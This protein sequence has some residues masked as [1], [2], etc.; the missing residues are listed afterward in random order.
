MTTVVIPTWLNN[1]CDSNLIK[2]QVRQS[3][4]VQINCKLCRI[5]PTFYCT[6]ISCWNECFQQ[7]NFKNSFISFESFVNDISFYF[8]FYFSLARKSKMRLSF[9]CLLFI[10]ICMT[11]SARYYG[12]GAKN[13]D[14]K[15][16][17][18]SAT[19]WTRS[20]IGTATRWTRSA[21]GTANRWTY[22]SIRWGG[23]GGKRG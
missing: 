19:R 14:K 23:W 1:C 17:Y 5:G 21:I 6:I 8:I 22:R 9:A 10:V 15:G 7:N 13:L 20:T 18:R 11:V 12:Y 16:W 2:R 3:G 4:I